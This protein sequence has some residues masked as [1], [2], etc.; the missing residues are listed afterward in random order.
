MKKEFYWLNQ[1]SRK[2]L[3]K[4]YLAEGQ[5]AEERIRQIANR[6]EEILG[7]PGYADKFYE[8]M[9]NGWYS[10]ASPVWSNFGAKSGL[11]ISCNGSYVCDSMACI[12]EKVAEVG[13]MSKHGAGTSVYFGDL[14]PRG[15]TV[16]GGGRSSGPVHFGE[17]FDTTAE[18]VSQ[19]GVRRGNVAA[20]LPVE[21]PDILEFLQIRNDGHAIQHMSIGVTITDAW[22]QAMIDGDVDK[23]KVWIKVLQKR[24]ESGYPYLFFTDTVNNGAPQVYKDKGMKIHASNLCTEICLSSSAEESFVCDLSSM[25]LVHW[26][27]WK[28]TDAVETMIYFLDAVMTEY[29]EKVEGIKFMEAAL[30]FAKNQRA[31][32]LGVL[33]WH[34][35]LQ[36]KM[37]AFESFEAKMINAQIFRG[38]QVQAIEASRKLATM[39]GEPELLKG[40]GLRNVTL[41]AIAPTTSSS[42]IL[43]QV[44]PGIELFEDNY[45]VSD[46]AK[47]K[48]TYK[49]PYLKEV[50]ANH[51]QDTKEVWQSILV[52]GG[53]VQHLSF[54]TQN[55]KDVFKTFGEVSQKEIIIQAAQRQKYIDQAQ[56][57][58]LKIHPDTPVKEV[59]ALIIEAWKLGV[60]TLYYQKSTN[61]A[62]QL[63]RS[64]LACK[65]C[66]A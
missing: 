21:H 30:R 28:D 65:S 5:T 7:I 66:E 22:F 52:R 8:Y 46:T 11:P 15:A 24:Y 47:G 14:R 57:I 23:R 61:P 6:A 64:I 56:S 36:S 48:I 43:G 62:Q 63:G 19:S 34:S 42:T 20:Y 32:G 54:L 9:G 45:F 18:V 33:G 13:M 17:L 4:G 39:F 27:E 25:N 40:Y 41:L 49:N 59:N 12:L 26:E 55:E 51:E 16:T 1:K 10:L 53:S 38:M 3:S 58:N 37:I 29:I 44:S 60:K 50:L 31:L 35:Y 2:F